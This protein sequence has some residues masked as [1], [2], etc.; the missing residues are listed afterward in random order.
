MRTQR[1]ESFLFSHILW[2]VSH[3]YQ[4]MY[5]G[6]RR[7][8]LRMEGLKGSGQNGV[9]LSRRRLISTT[10]QQPAR[11]KHSRLVDGLHEPKNGVTVWLSWRRKVSPSSRQP[12][13]VEY[14]RLL[15]CGHV[16]LSGAELS[17]SV[18]GNRLGL[19]Q[20]RLIM[21]QQILDGSSW[22]APDGMKVEQAKANSLKFPSQCSWRNECNAGATPL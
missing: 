9:W 8:F 22:E 10:S 11:V 17:L 1:H 13:S 3:R 15:R 18:V 6:G 2:Y 20:L 16:K 19:Y 21:M 12:S 7:R 5:A 4:T 14:S